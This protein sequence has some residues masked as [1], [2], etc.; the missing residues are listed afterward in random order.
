M[1]Y[2]GK[3]FLNVPVNTFAKEDFVGSDTGTNNSIANSLVLSRE[4][5]GL[6]ASN[7]EVFVNNIRQEPDVAYFIKD[8]ANGLPKILEFSEALAGSDEIYIIHKG[9]GPGTEKTGIAAG[10]ITASLLDDTLKTFTLDTFT[11]DNSTT[12]FVVD[13]KFTLTT[14]DAGFG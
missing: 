10:S 13:P 7:V 2:I 8:D 14:S 6:N 3:P 9:L 5:P 4:I 1:S 12:A 11:G